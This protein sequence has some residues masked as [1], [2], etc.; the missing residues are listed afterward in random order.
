MNAS[1]VSVLHI[2]THIVYTSWTK[3]K[4]HIWYIQQPGFMNFAQK[5]YNCLRNTYG[6][7]PVS[8]SNATVTWYRVSATTATLRL[9]V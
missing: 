1:I 8:V 5:C 6:T 3:L 7:M 9:M 4:L 2:S